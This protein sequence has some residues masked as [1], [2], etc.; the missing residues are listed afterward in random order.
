MMPSTRHAI[1]PDDRLRQ[2]PLTL[3][4]HLIERIYDRRHAASVI[5]RVEN[6]RR[7]DLETRWRAAP[8]LYL[9]LEHYLVQIDDAR[10]DRDALREEVKSAYPELIGVPR[11]GLIFEPEGKQ[12]VLLGREFL[13]PLVDHVLEL[14]GPDAHPSFGAISRWLESLSLAPGPQ[15]TPDH[16]MGTPSRDGWTALLGRLGHD[17]FERLRE[18]L[19]RDVATELFEERYREM[20]DCYLGLDTFPA[21]VRLFPPELLDDKKLSLLSRSQTRQVLL[22]KLDDIQAANQKLEEN[23]ADLQMALEILERSN[24]ELE[25]RVGE[26]TRELVGAKEAVEAS[27]ERLRRIS[28]A[29]HDAIIMVDHRGRATYMNSAAE[30]MLGF[31]RDELLGKSMLSQVVPARYRH[32]FSRTFRDGLTTGQGPGMGQTNEVVLMDRDGREFPV[33]LAASAVKFGE[34]WNLVGVVRDISQRK[35]QEAESRRLEDQLQEAQRL[36]SLGVLSGGIAH[37]FNNLLTT[38]L[39][40]VGIMEAFAG[41]EFQFNDSLVEIRTAVQRMSD[42][43]QQM[44][45]YS[46]RGHFIVEPVS[47]AE[48][49][50]D[51]AELLQSSVSKRVHLDFHF[52]RDLPKVMA[53]SGQLQQVV[54]NL[55]TNASDAMGDSDGG[56]T[57]SARLAQ[58]SREW[59]R[60]CRT[61]AELLPGPYVLLEVK[62]S[63][64]GM[65]E[66]T[67]NRMFEPFFT[68]RFT[69]RGLG[70]AAVLGIVRGHKGAIDVESTPGE[71]T[72]VRILLPPAEQPAEQEPTDEEVS[73]ASTTGTILVVD[74]EPGVRF[75]ARMVLEEYGFT[76]LTAEDGRAALRLFEGQSDEIDL[77]L[78]DLTM[79]NMDG[80]QTLVALHDVRKDT[81]VL[82]SSG[83]SRHETMK[84]FE[85]REVAGFVPKPYEVESLVREVRRALA[86]QG[87]QVEDQTDD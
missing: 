9:L 5:D 80:E 85:G 2:D 77:V 31:D 14:L 61:G 68:T 49:V 11:L 28:E 21:V 65:D 8:R 58:V 71:G 44:L 35:Q 16:A 84:R 75:L 15:Q 19:G 4:D 59:L 29:A 43:T 47:F 7:Q 82:L 6:L 32:H 33:E 83:Y 78:L 42:L 30:A 37:D 48:L 74:D 70:L 39:G 20:A 87:S 18:T 34:R 10:V 25:A 12:E 76:V 73:A 55:I 46:G 69:G 45:A 60:R 40:H 51:M 26:R 3:I 50:A 72:T 23:N 13:Q 17:L 66:D 1:R 38:V 56:V 86:G 54:M 41:P 63:G 81:R 27:E 22:D 53:D 62:D 52:D 79:P 64:S 67:S 36:E 24:E 57:V